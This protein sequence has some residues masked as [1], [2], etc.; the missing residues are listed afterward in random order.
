MQLASFMMPDFPC[1][2]VPF[3]PQILV[4][5]CH[6]FFSV[7]TPPTPSPPPEKNECRSSLTKKFV[8][9]CGAFLTNSSVSAPSRACCKGIHSFYDGS[10][11]PFCLC[12][13]ANGDISQLLPA[14]VTNPTRGVDVL[15]ACK[16]NLTAQEITEICDKDSTDYGKHICRPCVVLRSLYYLLLLVWFFN[17]ETCV[18]YFECLPIAS[19]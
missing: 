19:N 5:L 13:V 4:D 8:P 12:H 14:P 6:A 9:S 7:L 3:L 10:T 18:H 2:L 16:I 15:V 11:T 17:K 1:G